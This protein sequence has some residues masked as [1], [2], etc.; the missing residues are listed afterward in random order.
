M[1][2]PAACKNY[3]EPLATK[4]RR[5]PGRNGLRRLL[6]PHE[7]EPGGRE[8]EAAANGGKKQIGDAV[9]PALIRVESVD[10]DV[11]I[12]AAAEPF[13]Q[14]DDRHTFDGR[15]RPDR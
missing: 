1:M 11:W 12:G 15:N 13:I 4:A 9:I 7:R 3:H 2:V 10:A 14:I 8:L 5:S 6:T